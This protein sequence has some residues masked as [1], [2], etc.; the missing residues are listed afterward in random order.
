MS[1]SIEVSDEILEHIAEVIGEMTAQI[2]CQACDR[3]VDIDDDTPETISLTDRIQE[4]YTVM[5]LTYYA[6]TTAD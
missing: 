3:M 6:E 1:K 5:H 4:R 2:D